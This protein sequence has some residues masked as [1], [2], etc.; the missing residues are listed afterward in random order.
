M[1]VTKGKVA[2]AIIGLVVAGGVLKAL[3]PPFLVS[4]DVQNEDLR[5]VV[6]KLERQTG[7]SILVHK[8]LNGRIT[9]NVRRM[10]LEGVLT[11]IGDQASAQWTAIYPLY[12]TQQSLGVLEKKLTGESDHAGA[13]T[14]LQDTLTPMP[15][16]MPGQPPR[17]QQPF[18]SLNIV[19]QDLEM[20]S[21]AI[22]NFAHAKLV[23]ENGTKAQITLRASRIPVPKAVAQVARQAKRHWTRLFVL[24]PRAKMP[25]PELA[26]PGHGRPPFG[27][28][29]GMMPPPPPS[30]AELAAMPPEQR[31]RIEQQQEFM[32]QQMEAQLQALPP[33]Q[34]AQAMQMRQQMEAMRNMTPQQRQQAMSQMG[35]GGPGGGPGGPGPGGA[36]GASPGGS[37]ETGQSIQQMNSTLLNTTSDQRV[38]K[39]RQLQSK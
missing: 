8:D 5:S 37:A 2:L 4:M 31:Q 27:P 33:A 10:P 16:G 39:A 17:P 20:T 28:G 11:V 6:R 18:I 24:E 3:N 25:M 23:P 13:W 29:P 7:E 30:D 9:F 34:R 14:N 22:H 36:G 32:K 38:D 35:G 1:K 19:N 12:T 21:L 15:G 26:M